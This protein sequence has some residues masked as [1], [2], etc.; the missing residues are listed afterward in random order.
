MLLI[1]RLIF[2]IFQSPPAGIAQLV[3]RNLAK[4]DVAGSNPVSRSVP[5][6]VEGGR[7]IWQAVDKHSVCQNFLYELAPLPQTPTRQRGFFCGGS[8]NVEYRTS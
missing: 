2:D 3:E 1:R 7:D 5:D 4:V 8:L 6:P